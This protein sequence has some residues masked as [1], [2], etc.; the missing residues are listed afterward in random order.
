[1]DK[2]S[3]LLKALL[4]QKRMGGARATL[5]T[6]NYSPRATWVSHHLRRNYGLY[7]HLWND[8]T[9]TTVEKHALKDIITWQKEVYVSQLIALSA[10]TPIELE[11][12]FTDR[13]IC[14]FLVVYGNTK[15][16][17]DGNHRFWWLYNLGYETAYFHTLHY[18]PTARPI[19]KI[20]IL[21]M[22]VDNTVRV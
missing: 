9:P 14:P 16:L 12:L 20:Q 11:S 10:C 2:Q 8:D 19:K 5:P 3:R 22:G 7:K 13:S 17:C 4:I 21:E 1:M 15:I 6:P 18:D